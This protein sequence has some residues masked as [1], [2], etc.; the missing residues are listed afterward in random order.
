MVVVRLILLALLETTEA[1]V[2]FL[3]RQRRIE[4]LECQ[5]NEAEGKVL[6]LR[7][8]VNKVHNQLDKVKNNHGQLLN[9]PIKKEDVPSR[10]NTMHA[11]KLNDAETLLFCPMDSYPKY[12]TTS[13]MKCSSQFDNFFSDNPVFASMVMK[14][15]E[16]G[17]YRNGCTQ[18]IRAIERNLLDEKLPLPGDNIND[19]Q[20]FTK[21][22]SIISRNEQNVQG[23]QNVGRCAIATP[24]TENIASM[25]N[26]A[27]LE[28]C[29]NTNSTEPYK[30]YRRRRRETQNGKAKSNSRRRHSGS[31]PMKPHHKKNSH[32][33]KHS[34]RS[35]ERV[36]KLPFTK[37]QNNKAAE[38]FTTLEE[39]LNPT[40][41]YV[42]RSIRKRKIKCWDDFATS[43]RPRYN[44]CKERSLLSNCKTE[45]VNCHVKSGKDR[46]KS[47]CE[48]KIK[49]EIDLVSAS[50]EVILAKLDTEYGLDS[51]TDK[52]TGLLNES[53][54]VEKDG[55]EIKSFRVSNVGL[56][57]GTY[58]IPLTDSGSGDAAT[59]HATDGVFSQ[60]VNSRFVKYTFSRK[61]KKESSTEPQQ[62]FS[63]RASCVKRRTEKQND[64]ELQNSS[65]INEASRDREQLVHVAHQLIS[66]SDRRL[67]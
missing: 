42:R 60:A 53:V 13:Q 22:K 21:G 32:G 16:P 52:D 64:A 58:K 54:L 25:K 46:L 19:G 39:K 41:D 30:V 38:N 36:C 27:G 14:R 55:N 12:E 5:L 23:E 28:M 51:A 44:P 37:T 2:T 67:L 49:T 48:T 4:E 34:V 24:R 20:V 47:E 18:R 3:N 50:P 9:H 33:D 31:Q 66:L 26:P 63:L 65:L 11:K 8:E 1:E 43:C 17:L 29:I 40:G 62:N 15:K 57:F 56:N 10:G 45:S 35:G 7:V 61:C 59:S 6:D